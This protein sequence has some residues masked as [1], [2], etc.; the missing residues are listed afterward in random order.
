MT[1]TDHLP[2]APAQ[3]AG[4]D[5]AE[6]FEA[7]ARILDLF[8]LDRSLGETL[9]DVCRLIEASCPNSRCAILI[10]EPK[11]TR[12]AA[13]PNLSE[14]VRQALE[15][16]PTHQGDQKSTAAMAALA[17]TTGH[18]VFIE[19]ISSHAAWEGYRDAFLEE[20]L[21]ACWSI[22]LLGRADG[23]VVGT[24]DLFQS[25][26][27]EPT[28]EER[29]ILAAAADL[30]R[31][32]L[33]RLEMLE[34]LVRQTQYDSLTGLP[35]RTLFA[36]RLG[37]LI[38]REREERSEYRFAVVALDIDQ[39]KNIND[40]LGF[41]MGD[42]LLRAIGKRL[43][44]CV[45]KD[46]TVAR[47]SGDEFLLLLRDIHRN[48]DVAMIAQKIRQQIN[49]P[50]DFDGQGLFVTA[51]LGI[52]VYPWDGEDGQT[53][54]RNAETA[55]SH[56]KDLG[57]SGYQFFRP[58]MVRNKP[59]FDD[60]WH[61]SK[62]ASDLRHALSKEEFELYYQLKY[63][64]EGKH[65]LGAEALI[66]WNH[67]ELGLLLP[68]KFIPMSEQTGEI[69]PMGAW[70]LETACRQNKAWQDAGLFRAPV[71]VNVT[72]QQ[73]RQSDLIDLIVRVLDETGLGPAYLELEITESLAMEGGAKSL[74]RLQALA[75][76]GVSLT[77]DD[78]GTG[79][80]SL[81]YLSR[82]PI[83]TLK[84]DRSFIKDIG[85]GNENDHDSRSLVL[86]IL[87]VAKALQLVTVAEGVET[88]EQL[89]FM[90]EHSCDQIQ[91][92]LLARPEAVEPLTDRLFKRS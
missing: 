71:A 32:V 90:R 74:S 57:G 13:A 44:D 28:E 25:E 52:S 58:T 17:A 46:D 12:L 42:Y 69:I 76:L 2:S 24:I 55:L 30:T 29:Q 50:Y 60:W 63:D 64:T 19:Q 35:N 38:A 22:P 86:A 61:R 56:A 36:R 82:Y 91:G 73:F 8:R 26:E 40:T 3:S 23:E 4:L 70:A 43:V 16:V 89:E 14:P 41:N 21:S 49:S 1:Q 9:G 11:G 84:I 92:F 67:P 33:Q 81:S 6:R 48:D 31:A 51:T 75:D 87:S 45:R 77:I 5:A 83:H 15:G 88:E 39:L 85:T 78:F 59:T 80:S 10:C 68:G 7:Q 37:A 62:L 20:T 53:L 66:R 79:F 47:T 27:R 18:P 72:A 34:D 65:I 54:L